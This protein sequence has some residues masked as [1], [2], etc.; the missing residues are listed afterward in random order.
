MSA[1]QRIRERRRRR[2]GQQGRAIYLLP[3]MITSASLLFGFWSIILSIHQQF[4]RAALLIL[5]AGVCDM[6]DGR[7]A[8]ATR[9]TSRFGVEYDSISDMVSFG[10]APALLVYNMVLAPNIPPAPMGRRGWLISALFAL[11]AGL[12]LARFNLPTPGEK[13]PYYQGIPSTAAGGF[14]AATVFFLNWLGL[15]PPF[16]KAVGLTLT[17][18]F[19]VLAL[20]MVSSIP[21]PSWRVIHLERRHTF[22]VLVVCVLGGV[23]L[24]LHREWMMFA[25]GSV[26]VVSGPV[27]WLRERRWRAQASVVR[28]EDPETESHGNG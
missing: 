12:R 25:I 24:L 15:E 7:V 16:S 28:T 21:Y 14:V 27:V 10:M 5:V 20:L 22:P 6:L 26:F 18:G 9:S 1:R 8:R 13:S 2:A 4:E 17:T 19:A 3:N 11:C 23:A